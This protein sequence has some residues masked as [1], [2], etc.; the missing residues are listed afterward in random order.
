M[1]VNHA[2]K[3][4]HLHGHSTVRMTVLEKI[5]SNGVDGSGWSFVRYVILV[6]E[7]RTDGG[8]SLS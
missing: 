1:M 7:I 3:V 5:A 8:R 6:L 4:S 2:E